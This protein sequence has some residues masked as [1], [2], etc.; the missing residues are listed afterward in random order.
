MSTDGIWDIE[1]LEDDLRLAKAPHA[2]VIAL[3]RLRFLTSGFGYGL[4]LWVDI[5]ATSGWSEGE[6]SQQTVL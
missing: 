1:G 4:G 3:W 2:L 5:F 6:G